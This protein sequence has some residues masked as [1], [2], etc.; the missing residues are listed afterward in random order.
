M[1]CPFVEHNYIFIEHTV[2]LKIKLQGFRYALG[3][4]LVDIARF[5]KWVYQFILLPVVYKFWLFHVFIKTFVFSVIFILT[6][7]VRVVVS[8]CGFN[9]HF[10]KDK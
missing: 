7:L 2:Y 6:I 5:S 8:H 10:P 3:S 4:A 1:Y 9:L